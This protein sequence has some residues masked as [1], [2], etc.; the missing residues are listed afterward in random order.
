[1]EIEELP[2]NDIEL[3][4]YESNERDD[5]EVDMNKITG[6]FPTN[7]LSKPTLKTQD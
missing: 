1:M 3:S 2:E 5:E 6:S 7:L 4:N